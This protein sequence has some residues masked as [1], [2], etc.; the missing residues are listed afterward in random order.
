MTPSI[1]DPARINHHAWRV[2]FTCHNAL[3]LNLY[4]ALGK[5]HSVEPSGDHDAIPFDLSFDFRVFSEHYSLLGYNISLHV[6]VDTKRARQCQCA[7]ERHALIDEARPL[8]T[9]AIT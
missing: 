5:N 9:D 1:E 2:H 8:F 6:S 7:F 3:R 4:A